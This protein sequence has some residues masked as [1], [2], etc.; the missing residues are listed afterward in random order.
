M[1]LTRDDERARRICSLALEFMN[2]RAPLTSSAVARAFY[3]GLAPN[4]FRR[5]F[6]RDRTMLADCGVLIEERAGAGEESS[7]EVNEERSFAQGAELGAV[8]AMTLE[9]ACRPLLSEGGFPFA[10]ELRFALAKLNRTFAESV[11]GQDEGAAGE[12]RQLAALRACLVARHAASVT[13]VDA[14]GRE[15]ERVIAPYGFFD[16]HGV[17]YLVAG[18]V[19]AQGASVEGG[20]TRTYRVK[21]FSRVKEDSRAIFEV[22]PDF[23]VNDWRRLPFQMGN[24]ATDA[25]FEVPLA[26]EEEVRRASLGRGRFELSQATLV[27]HVEASSLEDAASWAVAQGI[28]PLGPPELVRAWRG[29]L[30]GA[31][32]HVS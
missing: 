1:E 12:S 20:A 21:R 32:A 11:S 18:R 9:L 22:P 26:R 28:R 31:L 8:E 27:W 17:L 25:T 23:D 6:A 15:S 29:V 7:W 19:D 16:L 13:Y 4:S 2:A 14:R 24:D 5:A 3:P 30:K 10:S